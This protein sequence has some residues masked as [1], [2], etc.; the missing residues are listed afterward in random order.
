[1]DNKLYS[2]IHDD[3]L[4]IQELCTVKLLLFIVEFLYAFENCKNSTE[5]YCRLILLRC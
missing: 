2:H 5:A 1:M 3:N 4:I